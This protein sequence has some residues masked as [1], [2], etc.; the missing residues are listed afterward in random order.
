MS[1]RPVFRM[2]ARVAPS[3]ECLQGLSRAY[4]TELLATK[5]RCIWQL[6]PMLNL[7]VAVLRDRLLLLLLLV[8]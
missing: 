3:G 6:F 8:G 2:C 1:S 4:L 7:V 5:R